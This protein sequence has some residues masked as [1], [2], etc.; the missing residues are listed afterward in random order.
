MNPAR[1]LRNIIGGS[2]GNLVEWFDG[3]AYSAFTLYFA[4][5]FLPKGDV[6]PGARA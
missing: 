6:S 1:P 2:A 5:V 3:F 4:P